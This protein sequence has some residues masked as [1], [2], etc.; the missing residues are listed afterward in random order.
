MKKHKTHINRLLIL[1]VFLII[2][3]LAVAF[4]FVFYMN[5]P[6]I[7]EYSITEPCQIALGSV[8]HPMPTQAS[9]DMQC[10][11]YCVSF[12]HEFK[13]AE[14]IYGNEVACNECKCFCIIR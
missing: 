1:Q 7:K 8:L 2:L 11:A 10:R 5:R 12:E 6:I 9:C 4:F 13:T 3:C 14:F